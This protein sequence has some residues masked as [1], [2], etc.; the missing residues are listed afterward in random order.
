MHA[1]SIPIQL[2]GGQSLPIITF[3]SFLHIYKYMWEY[4]NHA[5]SACIILLYM[6]GPSPFMIQYMHSQYNIAACMIMNTEQL[7][8]IEQLQALYM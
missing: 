6:F 2:H 8:Q 1:A 5:H 7:A 4:E 3:T